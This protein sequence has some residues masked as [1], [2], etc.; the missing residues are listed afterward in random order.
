[1]RVTNE[2]HN[3]NFAFDLFHEPVFFELLFF[4]DF[5]GNVFVRVNVSSMIDLSEIAL[6]EDLTQL[7]F[8]EKDVPFP[9]STNVILKGRRR[10]HIEILGGWKKGAEKGMGWGMFVCLLRCCQLQVRK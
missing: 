10:I 8:V 9:V 2:T 3:G 7:V 4:N 1:M 5:D 6:S